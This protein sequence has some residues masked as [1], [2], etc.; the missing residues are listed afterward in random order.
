MKKTAHPYAALLFYDF[1]LNEGQS[2]LLKQFYM[3]TN[4]KI[5]TAWSEVPM[6]FIDSAR[7]LDN[8]EQHIKLY[9]E[10]VTKR[11]KK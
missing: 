2:I 6:K 10:T 9:E 11:V 7:S 4:R 3:P 1:T 5:E 8:N